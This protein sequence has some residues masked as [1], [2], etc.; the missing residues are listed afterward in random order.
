MIY[1]ITHRTQWE[2]ALGVGYLEAASLSS[3]GFIHLCEAKQITGV[4]D[5]YFKDKNDL[6]LLHVDVSKIVPSLRY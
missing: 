2:K 4:L 5:R 3:E 6:V 1:H